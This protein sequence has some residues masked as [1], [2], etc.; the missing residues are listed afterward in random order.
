MVP[1]LDSRIALAV[2]STAVLWAVSGLGA[3]VLGVTLAAGGA[4]RHWWVRGVAWLAINVARGIPTSIVVIAAGVLGMQLAPPGQLPRLFP[5]TAPEFQHV[6]LLIALAVALG[7]AG[8]LAVIFI[9]S[10][11]AVGRHVVA[12]ARVM[13]MSAARRTALLFRES[14]RAAMPATG[15]R[16]V[17]HLH[18]TAF[19]GLFPVFEL[20][21]LLEER[22]TLT[23]QVWEYL[24]LGAAFYAGLSGLIW[25]CAL[26]LEKWLGGYMRQPNTRRSG[27]RSRQRLWGRKVATGVD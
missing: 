3:L 18:N 8:H 21:G 26:G 7:S 12:Q 5:G 17:H 24:L 1:V 15:A 6:G 27:R 13:G 19:A 16:M 10:R 22:I 2:A 25:L 14:A 9:A 4:S 23:F 11:G 20:F